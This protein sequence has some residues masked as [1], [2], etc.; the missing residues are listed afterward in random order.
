MGTVTV[1]FSPAASVTPWAQ[2]RPS[3]GAFVPDT[4][5]VLSYSSTSTVIRSPG[6]IPEISPRPW[7]RSNH[8]SMGVAM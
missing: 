4:M 1:L 2:P 5:A 3:S 7:E 8:A 6:G